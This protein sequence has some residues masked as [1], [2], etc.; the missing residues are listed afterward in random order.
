MGETQYA[1]NILIGK[2]KG[3]HQDDLGV[4]GRAISKQIFKKWDG[5]VW[6]GFI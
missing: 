2:P 3:D 6:N 1:C 5:R 4:D